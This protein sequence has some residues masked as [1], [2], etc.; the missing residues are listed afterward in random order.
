MRWRARYRQMSFEPYGVGIRREI[1]LS[2][3]IE[4]VQY[5]DRLSASSAPDDKGWLRQSR[6]QKSDWR[7][8]KEYRYRGDFA[9]RQIKPEG[10]VLFC[11]TNDEAERLRQS[12]GLKVIP[13][14]A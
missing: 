11:R 13:F 9:L 4:S 3:G 5:V 6:G 10:L 14:V 12:F 7:Q 8:E 1:A 2:A